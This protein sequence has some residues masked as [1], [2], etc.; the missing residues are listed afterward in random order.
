VLV[1]HAGRYGRPQVR[2][3][4]VL[5]TSVCA[6]IEYC[7]EDNVRRR[8][9]AGAARDLRPTRGRDGKVGRQWHAEGPPAGHI[10]ADTFAGDET[11][12]EVVLVPAEPARLD[13]AAEMPAITEELPGDETA[14]VDIERDEYAGKVDM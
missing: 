10:I 13:V 9:P 7:L 11:E 5:V 1:N 8:I 4:P 6:V 3:P 12:Q 14:V 2:R